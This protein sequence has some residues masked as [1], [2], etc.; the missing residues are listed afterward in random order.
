MFL[1]IDV[2]EVRSKEERIMLED[3]QSWMNGRIINE[4]KDRLG[5][6]MV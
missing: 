5:E 1:G 4:I 3:V 2:E 6:V